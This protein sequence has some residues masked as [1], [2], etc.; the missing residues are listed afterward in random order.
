M[1]KNNPVSTDPEQTVMRDSLSVITFDI[2]FNTG[3][4]KSLLDVLSLEVGA[5]F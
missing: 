4:H 1:P 2:I 5:V 3:I